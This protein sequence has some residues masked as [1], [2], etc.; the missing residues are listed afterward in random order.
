MYYRLDWLARPTRSEFPGPDRLE[1]FQIASP[2]D[3]SSSTRLR[4]Y[5][6]YF[7]WDT[8]PGPRRP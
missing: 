8:L 4:E 3:H 1:D 2:R 6:S 7:A 5:G